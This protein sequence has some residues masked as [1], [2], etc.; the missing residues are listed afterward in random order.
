VNLLTEL[1]VREEMMAKRKQPN[2][3]KVNTVFTP[4]QDWDARLKRVMELLIRRPYDKDI[5][6]PEGGS[7]NA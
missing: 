2:E 4:V 3:L 6:N 5:D 1:L 7:E